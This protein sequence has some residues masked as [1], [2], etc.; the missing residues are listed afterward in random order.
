MPEHRTR[1]EQSHDR[2]VDVAARA[3]RSAGY[4]GMGLAD[5]MKEA[6]LTHGGFYAHFASR[7]ALMVQAMQ[8]AGRQSLAE[9]SATVERRV[10]Q[11]HSRLSALLGAYLHDSHL[12]RAE[13]SCV[14]AALVS[15]MP[16]LNPALRDE[17]RCRIAELVDCVRSALPEGAEPAQAEVVT[18]TMLGALQLARTLGGAAGRSLL[19]QT[20]QALIEQ[21]E[22]SPSP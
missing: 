7:D 4:R 9:L 8:R 17:A 20:R 11:G 12:E 21:H 22:P 1:K 18:A 15:E 5:I 2:I 6:G 10:A 13:Q 16:R 3:L 14:L 19:A